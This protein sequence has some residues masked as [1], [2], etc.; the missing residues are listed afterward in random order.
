MQKS[1]SKNSSLETLKNILIRVLS[2]ELKKTKS[3]IRTASNI[4]SYVCPIKIEVC[5]KEFEEHELREN[6]NACFD[7][8]RKSG[9]ISA[10]KKLRSAKFCREA[11]IKLRPKNARRIIA[12]CD[13]IIRAA[14]D[15]RP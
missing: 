1:F 8:L 15:P 10:E 2:D 13:E 4:V 5:G 9:R 11:A 3:D 14:D 12:V 6:M 7:V